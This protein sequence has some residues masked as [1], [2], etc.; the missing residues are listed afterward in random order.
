MVTSS[1]TFAAEGCWLAEV[2][3]DD[4]WAALLVRRGT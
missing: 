2:A 1:S 4:G 3:E